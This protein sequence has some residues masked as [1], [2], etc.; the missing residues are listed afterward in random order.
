M[1]TIHHIIGKYEELLVGR[2]IDSHLISA[3]DKGLTQLLSQQDSMTSNACIKSIGKQCTELDTSNASLRKKRAMLLD[4]WKEMRQ[5]R[6]ITSHNSLAKECSLLGATNIEDI[7]KTSNIGQRKVCSIRG[8][9]VA[10]TRTI[11]IE[12]DVMLMTDGTDRLKFGQRIDGAE[13][14]GLRDIEHARRNHV[15]EGIITIESS[16][17]ALYIF[18]RDLAIMTRQHE[19]LM[20]AVLYGTTLVHI[21]MCSLGC[22]D[23]FVTP[24]QGINDR[25]IGL[26]TTH[27]ELHQRIRSIADPADISSGLI[28]I[29]VEA[30]TSRMLQIGLHKAR[31]HFRMRTF[32]IIGIKVNHIFLYFNS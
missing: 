29:M 25:C 28:A 12:R 15:L 11:E 26:S 10:Q 9:S 30:I 23:A 4:K 17:I 6:R 32:H 7:A 22:H 19:N 13:F 8:Q 18:G 16:D 20:S 3:V 31:Q 27:E 5:T 24:Q 14:G 2:R 1:E 21:D